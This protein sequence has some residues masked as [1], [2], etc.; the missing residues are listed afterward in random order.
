MQGM[1]NGIMAKTKGAMMADAIESLVP[2]VPLRSV[3]S[4]EGGCYTLA[5]DRSVSHPQQPSMLWSEVCCC[6]WSLRQ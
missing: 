2:D 4:H 3:P 6:V 1:V 5:F